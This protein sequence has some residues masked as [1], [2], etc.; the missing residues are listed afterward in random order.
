VPLTRAAR[1]LLGP[2]QRKGSISSTTKGKLRFTGYGKGRKALDE[3]IA[4]LRK[5][6]ER[7]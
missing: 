4:V 7:S 1:E 6:A 3:K 5:K 2:A